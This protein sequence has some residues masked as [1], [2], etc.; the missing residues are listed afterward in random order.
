MNQHQRRRL[1]LIIDSDGNPAGLITPSDVVFALTIDDDEAET[2]G[3][4]Q[5]SS[6]APQSEAV[7]ESSALHAEGSNKDRSRARV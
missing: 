3:L 7:S 6:G 5:Q 1:V 4:R 2:V